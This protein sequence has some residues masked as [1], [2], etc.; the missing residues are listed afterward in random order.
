MRLGKGS[1]G[2][3]HMFVQVCTMLSY[4]CGVFEDHFCKDSVIII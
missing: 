3:F 4:I 1:L 2:C